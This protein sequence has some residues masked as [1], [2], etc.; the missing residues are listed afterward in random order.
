[1]HLQFNPGK[2]IHIYNQDPYPLAWRWWE[3][4]HALHLQQLC[5]LGLSEES[6]PPC[7]PPPAAA[8][9]LALA[10]M[11]VP[12]EDRGALL[13]PEPA[14]AAS[15]N[16]CICQ[17]LGRPPEQHYDAKS[18]TLLLW[19]HPLCSL[20]P[21]RVS[22]NFSSNHCKLW[23]RSE[24]DMRKGEIVN[25]QPACIVL[26]TETCNYTEAFQGIWQPKKANCVTKVH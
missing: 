10:W 4:L 11:L 25:I 21:W 14:P 3:R 12:L 16:N 26:C 22:P 19:S 5:T 6:C 9:R 20:Q 17:S 24:R 1:M 2:T 15:T 23:C 7:T 13:G 18:K 8:V